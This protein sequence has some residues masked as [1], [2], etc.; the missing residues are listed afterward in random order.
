MANDG[1]LEH[2][3]VVVRSDLA[4]DALP[5]AGGAVD[6]SQIEVVGRI[7][8]WPGGETKEA[9]FSLTAGSYV[10]ICNIPGHYQLGMRAAF[11]VQPN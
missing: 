2:E 7:E 5:Q 3:F 11:R 1:A 6:E 10:L 8:Q 9:T 4:V